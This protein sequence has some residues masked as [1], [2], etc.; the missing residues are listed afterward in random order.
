MA[1]RDVYAALKA[2]GIETANHESDLYARDSLEARRIVY[3]CGYPAVQFRGT[4][5]ALWL[6][7][8]FAFTPFWTAKQ[9]A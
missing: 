8:P 5:G 7:L 1:K 3:A 2:A 4:D 9:R 6:D